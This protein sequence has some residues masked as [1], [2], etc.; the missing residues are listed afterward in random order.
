VALYGCETWYLKAWKELSV[1]A[2]KKRRGAEEN[3]CI[4]EA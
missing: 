3:I 1:I 2:F 4:E